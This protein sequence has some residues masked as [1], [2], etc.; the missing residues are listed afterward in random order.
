MVLDNA[1]AWIIIITKCIINI[2][3]WNIYKNI[4]RY[5]ISNAESPEL[6]LWPV[7]GKLAEE[8][9]SRLG[10]GCYVFY[11]YYFWMDLGR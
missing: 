8:S 11:C 2:L 1:S 9:V 7:V 6:K 4:I 5:A 3:S 10:K